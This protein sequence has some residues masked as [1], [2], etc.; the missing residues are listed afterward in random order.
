M[1]RRTILVF[2]A[3]MLCLGTLVAW[4]A[5]DLVVEHIAVEPQDPMSGDPVTIEVTVRNI[6]RHDAD[7]RF[8]VRFTID[9]IDFDTLVIPSGLDAGRETRISTSWIA[10]PGPHVI[11]VEVDQPFDRVDEEDEDNNFAP[12]E[13]FIPFSPD[14]A[15]RLESL[16]VVVAR[17]QDVSGSGFVNAAEGIARKVS[18]GL[19]RAG[20]RVLGTGELETIM[21]ERGL[22]PDFHGDVVLAAREMGADVVVLGSIDQLSVHQSSLD[23]GF[24][25]FDGASADVAL[26]SRLIDVRSSE[27]LSA[28]TVEGH[29]EGSTGFSV[30]VGSILSLSEDVHVCDGGLRTEESWY[31]TGNSI[32]IGYVNPSPASWYSL[33]IHTSNNDFI[34][35]LGWQYISSGACGKWTWDQ[36]DAFGNQMSPGIYTAKL[37]NGSSY[38]AATPIQIRPGFGVSIP[39]IDE[40]TVGSESFDETIVG[41]AVNQAVT[42]LTSLLLVSLE[43]V[44]GFTMGAADEAPRAFGAME[45]A[46]AP[47][48]MFQPLEGQV[49]AILPNDRMAINIGAMSGVAKGD[50]FEV[51]AAENVVTDPQTLEILSYD[52]VGFK[53]EIVIVEVRDRVS[54]GVQTIEFEP[55]VGDIVRLLAP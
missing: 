27:I 50:F 33:E 14:S 43:D 38:V 7:E 49:A 46:E 22:N 20:V 40:I 42:Q 44:A 11:A 47:I 9:G 1:K 41:S 35:W 3:W 51:V 10:S 5:P 19:A 54:Y 8:Y 25:R 55:A 48:P 29:D 17:F 53:G 16:R 31:Y 32:P 12:I 24:V 30:D 13:L 21:Q 18:D 45:A 4:S 26:S 36:R 6:G 23:L 34:R 37:W 15:A 52:I 28:L 39:L 2:V